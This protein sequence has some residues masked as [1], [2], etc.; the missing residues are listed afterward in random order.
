MVK[1]ED[2]TKT[3]EFSPFSHILGL[4]VYNHDKAIGGFFVQ[5]KWKE[6]TFGE[7]FGYIYPKET[8]PKTFE[9]IG[10]FDGIGVIDD[11]YVVPLFNSRNKREGEQ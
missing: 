8:F 5:G 4:R 11:R 7:F 10:G 6:L 3:K 1:P 2:L 9:L